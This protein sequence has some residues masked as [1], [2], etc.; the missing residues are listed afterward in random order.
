MSRDFVQA[1]EDRRLLSASISNGVVS[2]YGGTGADTISIT[3]TNTDLVT[4]VNTVVK[5][6]KLTAVTKIVIN[7]N[8]GN[9][10]VTV[11]TNITKPTTING[12]D[13]ADNISGGGGIDTIHGGAGNDIEK[14]NG[15]N[16]TETG[17]AG[18]D[19]LDGGDG[20]DNL[21]GNDGND[22]E[23]GGAGN[24]R[25]SGGNGNDKLLGG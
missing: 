9:D 21:Q 13:G 14:G 17:D 18:D 3:K 5:S 12:G 4:K 22:T 24:D 19:N 6:F 1:L 10:K 8:G 15:G 2:V 23:T 7:A 25:I 11:A 16:D 20:S